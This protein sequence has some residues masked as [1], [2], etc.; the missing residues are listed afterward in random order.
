MWEFVKHKEDN[1][2]ETTTANPL[3]VKIGDTVYVRQEPHVE[4]NTLNK[5]FEITKIEHPNVTISD[6]VSQ[7]LVH[8][9]RLFE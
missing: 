9:N 7:M 2:F 8:K 1:T 4:L 3:K 5:Q 6:G